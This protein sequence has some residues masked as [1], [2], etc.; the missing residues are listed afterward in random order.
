MPSHLLVLASRF[1]CVAAFNDALMSYQQLGITQT[2]AGIHVLSP[3]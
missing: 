1:S 2:S 3:E